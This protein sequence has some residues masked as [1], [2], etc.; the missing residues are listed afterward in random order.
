MGSWVNIGLQQECITDIALD[1]GTRVTVKID[2][3]KSRLAGQIV[4]PEE[5]RE[6]GTYWGYSVRLADNLS[7]VI[8]GCQFN[9]PYD[10]TIGTSDRGVAFDTVDWPSFRHAVI[11]FGGLSGLE[12]IME[13]EEI[14]TSQHKY[15]D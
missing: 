1:P 5:P 10:L 11:Y 3:T 6:R 7:E 12:E 9:E 2:K 15:F 8:S 4:S 14:H 13:A